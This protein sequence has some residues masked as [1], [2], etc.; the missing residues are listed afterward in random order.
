M[1]QQLRALAAKLEDPSLVLKTH[2]RKLTE[3]I[4]NPLLPS[5]R[6]NTQCTYTYRDRHIIH[7]NKKQI[8][9][10]EDMPGS[11]GSHL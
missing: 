10:K 11:G 7:T 6:T 9:K 3:R 5:S 2:V 4:Q 8:F 1:A